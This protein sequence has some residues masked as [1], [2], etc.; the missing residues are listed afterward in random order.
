MTQGQG[1]LK[2]VLSK[3]RPILTIIHADAIAERKAELQQT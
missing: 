1:R 3:Y 2:T